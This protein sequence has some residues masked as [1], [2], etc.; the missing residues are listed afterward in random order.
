[1]TSIEV[2]GYGIPEPTRALLDAYGILK[3]YDWD[4]FI[5]RGLSPDAAAIAAAARE[6]V[7]AVERAQ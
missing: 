3:T 6:F 7:D 5:D 1:M 2:T 4:S